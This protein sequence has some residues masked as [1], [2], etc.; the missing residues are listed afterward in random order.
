VTA[1]FRRQSAVRL[2]QAPP[3]GTWLNGAEF[4]ARFE[5][6]TERTL[7]WLL[8]QEAEENGIPHSH[9]FCVSS[10]SQGRKDIRIC[11]CLI[12]AQ[13]DLRLTKCIMTLTLRAVS[14]VAC[15]KSDA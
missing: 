1:A 9:M 6:N 10:V 5:L 7:F 8:R 13:M 2:S 4:V 14:A 3:A 11:S 12:G 15:A